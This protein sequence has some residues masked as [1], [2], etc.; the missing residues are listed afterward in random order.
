MFRICAGLAVLLVM[1]V[2][3]LYAQPRISY[4][5]PDIAAPGMGVMMDVV[6]PTGQTGSFGA[7]GFYAN[8][9][10]SLVRIECLN[11]ADTAKLVFGPAV[12]SWQG[13]M[14]S[15][16]AFVPKRIT[17]NSADW[18]A[19]QAQYRIPV[20]VVVNG[21]PSAVDTVYLV[22][23]QTL[24]DISA[25]SGSVLGEGTLGRR[26]RRGAMIV[27]SLILANRT[28]TISKV[29]CDPGTP[30]NQGYLPAVILSKGAVRGLGSSTVIDV[31]GTGR[32]AGPGG[33]G[34][35]GRFCDLSGTGNDG[36]AGFTSGGKG[37]TNS[38]NAEK[39]FGQASGASGQSLNGVNPPA[40][41]WF[42]ASG[43]GTGHPF[44][45]SGAGCDS[46]PGCDPEGA[47]GG[48]SGFRNNQ[49]G[50]SGG[51]ATAAADR[52][53]GKV[54]GNA[55][56]VPLAGGSGGAS[57]NP[58]GFLVCSGDGGGG[59]G[60]LR[61]GAPLVQS[62][63]LRGNGAAGGSSGNGN[64]G[65]G[66]GGMVNVSSHLPMNTIALVTNG[67][68]S[69]AGAGRNR[70][71]SP[72]QPTA[73]PGSSNYRGPSTDTA[74]IVQRAVQLTGSGA[75]QSVDLWLKPETGAWQK[76]PS[77]AL[78]DYIGSTNEWRKNITLP[79]TDT[80]Y[81]LVAMQVVP[82]PQNDPLADE[83]EFVHSQSAWNIF[84]IDKLPDLVCE[85]SAR[86]FQGITCVDDKVSLSLRVKNV[87]TGALTI[88][89]AQTRLA[90]GT[91]GVAVLGLATNRIIPARDSSDIVV[92]W[93]YRA[94]QPAEI[95]DTLLLYHN[96]NAKPNP[97]RILLRFRRDRISFRFIENRLPAVA[98]DT[99]RLPQTCVGSSVRATVV[100]QSVSDRPF[101]VPQL[102][103][104]GGAG[105]TVLTSRS[106]VA[107]PSDSL[108]FDV[109]YTPSAIGNTVFRLIAFNPSC[110]TFDTVVVI[111]DSRNAELAFSGDGDLGIQRL[112]DPPISRS[113]V[114]KNIGTFGV[115]VRDIPQ[116]ALPFS[117]ISTTPALPYFLRPGE[118][119]NVTVSFSSN[120]VGSYS[121][122][123]RGFSAQTDS[124][125]VDTTE[126]RLQGQVAEPLLRAV[127]NPLDFGQVTSCDV[128][129]DTVRIIND[130]SVYVTIL[131]PLGLTGVAAADYTVRPLRTLPVRLNS[132]DTLSV[133]VE[134]RGSTGVPGQRNA[135][136]EIAT[137][138][139]SSAILTVPLRANQAVP[140]IDI[141]GS[142]AAG[143]F[144][145][146]TVTTL[147]VNIENNGTLDVRVADIRYGGIVQ[148][149]T[150][151]SFVLAASGEQQIAYT[152]DVQSGGSL[153]GF[154]EIIY[155]QPCA[156]TVRVDVQSFGM[157]PSVSVSNVLDFQR[158]A[159]CSQPVDTL[160]YIN[161]GDVP[162]DILSASLAGVDAVL[163]N[164][165]FPY[166]FPYTLLPGDTAF[167]LV[168]F[169]PTGSP[170]GV[171]A[172]EVMSVLRISS[173]E[174]TFFTRLA[175]EHIVPLIALP[176]SIT[177]GPLAIGETATVP[178]V[179]SN[180]GEAD[181]NISQ[182]LLGNSSVTIYPQQ[183]VIPAQGGTIPFSVTATATQAGVT[184]VSIGLIQDQPC[185]DTLFIE[186]RILGVAADYVL[187]DS[188][189]FP[190][191]PYCSSSTAGFSILNTGFPDIVVRSI[192]VEGDTDFTL[193]VQGALPR[194]LA[195]ADSVRADVVFIPVKGSVEQRRARAIVELEVDG[196][197]RLD[198]V[199]IVGTYQPSPVSVVPS[200][201]DFGQVE[202]ADPESEDI[203]V[204]SVYSEDFQ[205]IRAYSGNSSSDFTVGTS[206][207]ATLP[208]NG[209]ASLAVRFTPS[210]RGVISDTLW[211]VFSNG[212]CTDSIPLSVRGEGII[213]QGIAVTVYALENVFDPAS[214]EERIPVYG[215]INTADSSIRSAVL[216]FRVAFHR[217]VFVPRTVSSGEI[218]SVGEFGQ[219]R[220]VD[221]RVPVSTT[222][223]DTF[224][225]ADIIG[226]P[227]LGSVSSSS[228]SLGSTVWISPEQ[229]IVTDTTI[230]GSISLE[231]C[232]EGGERFIRSTGTLSRS[233][234]YPNPAGD[235][236]SLR[237][238]NPISGRYS[239]EVVSTRGESV[240]S[241]SVQGNRQ[242]PIE[243][244]I[245]SHTF[246]SGTYILVVRVGT[247]ET[248][249]TIIINR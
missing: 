145:V 241:T 224:K 203:S 155:D 132:S 107:N 78:F 123:L 106:G 71:D 140:D 55:Q 240:W 129:T 189:E 233:S 5:I 93:T 54:H 32:D 3:K 177:V 173:Q 242:S 188:L 168:N 50:G 131:S 113:V 37:G 209:T 204:G 85:D 96:D 151:T 231:I 205:I 150:P 234:V 239:F 83:P 43:G 121:E 80:V 57:G 179:V 102:R 159:S 136:M 237:V 120:T 207:P 91:D 222:G 210:R 11:P 128:K 94:G 219:D 227:T 101:A 212:V 202:V 118:E 59:G 66:S 134:F 147:T 97:K 18:Q 164:L 182:V 7:D 126:L 125:C 68:G 99:V 187:R 108:R 58:Q 225:I 8:A 25:N 235:K 44:G 52:R 110:A 160:R 26:S 33:G 184:V 75:R 74:H 156:D 176:N 228:V 214:R 169:D 20:R 232:E 215:R 178:I 81:F 115:T 197:T 53:G 137:D 112:G 39:S 146:G 114:L 161:T 100:L 157:E 28:Y 56:G 89:A 138:Y 82:T 166:A 154:I 218:V 172:A 192:R 88:D 111:A 248:T 149:V 79:G 119:M 143:S 77:V 167:V 211:I 64:G 47:H 29:D 196:V 87:G 12:V 104:Q 238:E 249:H 217:E 133:E 186:V 63:T 42:E 165:V 216:E 48:G 40:F 65:H 185:P 27:D 244:T 70:Y 152:I 142:I 36:G 181:A 69:G 16:M 98:T 14:L 31:S 41:A 117:V 245:P 175:A 10:G 194:T 135:V 105:L 73:T 200:A 46:G 153:S 45:I 174:R 24:G 221:I 13:R 86:V 163:F 139:S 226:F 223:S 246:A 130:G 4:I 49:S 17:P 22:R 35:G 34:G 198:T 236:I 9:P 30:G 84:E 95:V 38:P 6:A 76:L 195:T 21:T 141:P 247:R 170:G 15:V 158:V 19:L 109:E 72:A 201:V 220:I 180:S 90:R 67:G 23:P 124:S 191:I 60:A 103:V 208:A 183:A 92:E 127:P 171:K 193:A 116:V 206:L 51:Y 243:L 2:A 229:R 61:I 199:M 148:D 122:V 162:V 230:A 1:S 190:S 62:V 213:T 144:A